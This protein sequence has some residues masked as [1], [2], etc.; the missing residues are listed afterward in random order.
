MLLRGESLL[1]MQAAGAALATGGVILTGV[2]FDEGGR[3]GGR[4]SW[5]D[6]RRFKGSSSP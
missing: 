1:P 5:A 4:G 6:G 3:S 2:V